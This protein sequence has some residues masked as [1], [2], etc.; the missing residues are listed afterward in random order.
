MRIKNCLLEYEAETHTYTLDGRKVPSVTEIVS[1]IG[2]MPE[3]NAIIRRAAMRGERVHLLCELV[4][5]DAIP[6]NIDPEFL[7]YIQAYCRFV[8]DFRPKWEW[9]E[10]KTAAIHSKY[11]GRLDRYGLIDGYKTI[12]DIKT[13]SNMDRIAK[14]RLA[15]QIAGYIRTFKEAYDYEPDGMGV[16]LKPDGKYSIHP[17]WKIQEQ[18]CFNADDL[19]MNALKITKVVNGYE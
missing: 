1:V 19:F 14:I 17:L 12:V 10:C 5:Y 11:A 3:D 18:Y 2:G 15:C 9:I 8:R 16:Q 13:T 7:G 4:D 6:E